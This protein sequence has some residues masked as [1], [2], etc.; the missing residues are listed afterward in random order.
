MTEAQML[1]IFNASFELVLGFFLVGYGIGLIV[2]LIRDN[3]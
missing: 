1:E 2:K 3:V